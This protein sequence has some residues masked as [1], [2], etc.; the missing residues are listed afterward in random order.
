MQRTALRQAT[1]Q[2]AD[3]LY[4]LHRAALKVYVEQTYGPWDDEWQQRRFAQHYRPSECQIITLRGQDVGVVRAAEGDAEVCLGVIEILP[5][6]QGR[7]IGTSV[8]QS[9]LD[10]AHGKGKPVTLQVFKVNPARRLYTRL[11]F[12]TVGETETHYQ[13]RALP[14]EGAGSR[15][16][17]YDA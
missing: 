16:S 3:S 9:V 2:D 13:M 6:F 15:R 1:W 12:D 5:Q 7:G 8:I 14:P 17:E 10:K 11:G 4:R